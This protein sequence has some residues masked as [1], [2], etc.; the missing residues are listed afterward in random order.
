MELDAHGE[1]IARDCAIHLIGT[2]LDIAIAGGADTEITQFLLYNVEVSVWVGD[3]ATFI[4]RWHRKGG[5][6]GR[7][8][9]NTFYVRLI[10]IKRFLQKA[11]SLPER[12][13]VEMRVDIYGRAQSNLA[14]VG[15]PLKTSDP[16]QVT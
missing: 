7:V 11:Q 5:G 2:L 13:T 8:L 12:L 9:D 14:I 10:S 4:A 15:I 6:V 3:E 16:E 1:D